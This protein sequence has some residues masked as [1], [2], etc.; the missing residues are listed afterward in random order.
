MTQSDATS[1]QLLPPAT[2][3]TSFFEPSDVIFLLN[4]LLNPREERRNASYREGDLLA[5]QCTSTDPSKSW[6]FAVQLPSRPFLGSFFGLKTMKGTGLPRGWTHHPSMSNDIS[7]SDDI[8]QKELT[9][10]SNWNKKDHS[11]LVKTIIAAH[12]SRADEFLAGSSS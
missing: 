10:P 12:S 2:V 4:Y 11:D 3:L 8:S 5:C 7:L 9:M 1:G 6:I